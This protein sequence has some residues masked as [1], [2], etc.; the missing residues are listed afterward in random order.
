MTTTKSYESAEKR[1]SDLVDRFQARGLC[2]HC[3]ATA[4]LI[5]AIGLCVEDQGS[6]TVSDMLT[7]AAR[8]VRKLAVPAP[9][10]ATTH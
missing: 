6:D 7:E 8:D 2:L 9:D 5:R 10:Y 1:I 4:M 3:L